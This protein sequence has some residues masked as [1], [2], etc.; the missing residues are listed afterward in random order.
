MRKILTLIALIGAT[1]SS[2]MGILMIFSLIEFSAIK[3]YFFASLTITIGFSLSLTSF[4]LYTKKRNILPLI[5]FSLILL[6]SGMI[7]IAIFS[8]S[9]G[10]IYGKL[11][12]TFSAISIL[13][14]IIIANI[15]KL[16]KAYLLIQGLTYFILIY[17]FLIV[18]LAFWNIYKK[19]FNTVFWMMVILAFCGLISLSILSK[20][21]IRNFSDHEEFIKIK[22]E[23]YG[24][25]VNRVKTL[26]KILQDHN[27]NF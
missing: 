5:S 22:K 7:L 24:F 18:L 6:A 2:L 23:E 21:E 26:E 12:V 8:Q 27:I 1:I 16:E 4:N 11:T 13:F 9:I 25:L 19:G 20:R 3:D 10:L 14:A 17:I 15:T